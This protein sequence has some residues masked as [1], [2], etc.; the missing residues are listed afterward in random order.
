MEMTLKFLRT[1]HE[2][3]HGGNK[4]TCDGVTDPK[5]LSGQ[6]LNTKKSFRYK[7]YTHVRISE[8][9]S[10]CPREYA[11]GYLDDVAQ[12]SYI[13]FALQTQFDIGSALHFWLQNKSKVFK[14]ILCG[15]WKCEACG[16]LR[17]DK[18][19]KPYFGTKPKEPCPHCGANAN[20]TFYDE[21]MFR[22]DEPYRIV[23][24]IDAVIKKDGVYRFG[25]FKSYWQKP[26]TGF[27]T[28]K[29]I[30]Q[31]ASYAF[32]YQYVPEELK[33]PVNIDTS[34]SYLHYISK[35]FSYSESILTFP[36]QPS[37]KMTDTIANRV[38]EFTNA[39]KTGELPMPFEPCIRSDFK[40]GKA[41]NCFLAD[42]CKKYYYEGRKA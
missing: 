28:G 16:N 13:D 32:F 33:F 8:I 1:T 27:P 22:L 42:T 31:I 35:K 23:G 36:I 24:K 39:T 7:K 2:I 15:F 12:E 14:N 25:D 37:K 40:G 17:L 26:D 9:H 38:L 19:G 41:K 18:N 30:A 34:T 11:I 4:T 5:I 21:F 20:A 29:D 3:K 10:F 6:L